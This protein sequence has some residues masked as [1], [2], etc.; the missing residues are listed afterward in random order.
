MRW[1]SFGA[2]ALSITLAQS[3]CE[4]ETTG[5]ATPADVGTCLADANYETVVED[6]TP[7]IVDTVR[8]RAAGEEVVLSFYETSDRAEGYVESDRFDD[9][10]PSES[11][12]AVYVEWGE[13][14]P[15]STTRQRVID[16]LGS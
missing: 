15:A 2:V 9:E 13:R 11:F 16:C 6:D 5:E 8:F 1:G 12:G 10:G 4:L 7:G 14:E 3:G